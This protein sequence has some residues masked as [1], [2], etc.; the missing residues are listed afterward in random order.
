MQMLT[1]SQ[2]I[3]HVVLLEGVG[4]DSAL[5]LL[6]NWRVVTYFFHHKYFCM[7][8]PI[9]ASMQQVYMIICTKVLRKP[10]NELWPPEND[11]LQDHHQLMVAATLPGV[12][13]TPNHTD[14]G[15]IPWCITCN[16]DT[17]SYFFLSTKKMVSKNSVNFEK[18][19]HHDA[20][21]I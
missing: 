13:F 11:N 9:A 20:F 16:A 18:Q 2:D 17:W 6:T 10:K 3:W 15:I 12:N 19:Y 21:T 14:I 8:G 7:C 5:D 4:P 1:P